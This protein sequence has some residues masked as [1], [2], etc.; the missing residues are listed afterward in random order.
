MDRGEGDRDGSSRVF[1]LNT[2]AHSQTHSSSFSRRPAA[3]LSPLCWNESLRIKGEGGWNG[4]PQDWDWR[5]QAGLDYSRVVGNTSSA[6][7][8]LE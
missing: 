3:L 5:A 1:T 8:D 2:Y 6:L 4:G 7:F